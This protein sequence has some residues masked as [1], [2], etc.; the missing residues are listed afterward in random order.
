[1]R[2]LRVRLRLRMRL[3]IGLAVG[4]GVVRHMAGD[5]RRLRSCGF[6]G[7]SAGA[8]TAG[9]ESQRHRGGVYAL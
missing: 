3:R 5:I 7:R 2:R 1:V 6:A 4:E 9:D 8:I